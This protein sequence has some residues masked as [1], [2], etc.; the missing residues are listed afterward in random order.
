MARVRR[1][2]IRR[3]LFI[4]DHKC[5]GRAGPRL[6]R[7]TIN[8]GVNV[9]PHKSISRRGLVKAGLGAAAAGLLL[10][11]TT[12]PV[13]AQDHPALGTCPAG[14]SGSSIFIGGVFPLT[15]P[16]SASGKDKQLGFELAIDHLNNGSR[17]TE[18][19]P[20]LK[21]GGGLL[22]KK[23]EFAGRRTPKPSRIPPFRPRPASFA[24][25]RPSC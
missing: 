14:T 2:C 11:K 20:S 3:E 23:I 17:I 5:P 8:K 6:A 24:T 12:L 19:I 22:G 15:G 18:Q 21:K 16:Y 25:T 10:P 7:V 9:M 4:N 1:Q 13:L